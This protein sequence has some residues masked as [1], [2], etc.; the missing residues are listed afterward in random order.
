LKEIIWVMWKVCESGGD[1]L[2]MLFL[3][4]SCDDNSQFYS[5]D[6]W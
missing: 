5:K 1:E 6:V 3:K 4:S 2:A